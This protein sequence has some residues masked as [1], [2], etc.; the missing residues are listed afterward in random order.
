MFELKLPNFLWFRKRYGI[1]ITDDQAVLYSWKSGNL[2]TLGIFSN[3]EAGVTRFSRYM[4]GNKE[5][6]GKPFNVLVNVIG[7]DHRFEKVAHLIGKYKVDFHKRRMNQLFRGVEF[8]MSDVQ[9]RDDLGRREDL[10]LFYG[11]LSIE[12]IKP[13]LQGLANYARAFPSGMY[14]ASIISSSIYKALGV[15]EPSSLLI[16]SHEGGL[17]RQTFVVGGKVRFS[18]VSKV[19]AEDTVTFAKSLKKEMERMLQ[20][21]ASLRVSV[22]GALGVHVVCQPAMVSQL[23]E[24][25]SGTEKLKFSFHD[26]STVARNMGLSSGASNIGSDSSL[27]LQ[28]MFS[29]LRFNQLLP[30]A[31]VRFYWVS[32][33]CSTSVAAAGAYFVLQMLLLSTFYLDIRSQYT[34][35]SDKKQLSVNRLENN[36]RSETS[37]INPPSTPVNVR[38]VSNIYRAISEF[39]YNPTQI[40]YYL[41]SVLQKSGDVTVDTLSWT[42]ANDVQGNEDIIPYLT[43]ESVFQILKITGEFSEISGESIE[44]L[45]SRSQRFLNSFAKHPDIAVVPVHVPSR[46]QDSLASGTLEEGEV[47]NLIEDRSFEVN[48]VWRQIKG[49]DIDK[50][51]EEQVQL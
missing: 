46:E 47:L 5:L 41:S 21:L 34:V 25:L 40:I 7:E 18:R 51:L 17:V 39:T 48:I 13:W 37:A 36:Y 50:Y 11:L 12:K 49:S 44:Q 32:L 43:G 35:P 23:R 19:T 30:L 45:I 31:R 2:N 24:M 20:Y 6:H 28:S 27:L 15:T 26:A 14:A 38:S 33:I 4:K 8:A 29:T 9:G 22:G 1:L 3:D 16:T 10:V 42:L